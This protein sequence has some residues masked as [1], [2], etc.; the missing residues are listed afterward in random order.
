MKTIRRLALITLLLIA[1][2]TAMITAV[3]CIPTSAV[4]ENVEKSAMQIEEDGLWYKPLGFFLFQID[5]MTDCQML[6]I[7][8]TADS[9]QP[10]W[11]AMMAE[12][13][14]SITDSLHP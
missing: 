3:F 9:R 7:N 8:A 1:L 12:E 11:A 5:N 14:I 4:R 2:F 6:L 13:Y 10:V